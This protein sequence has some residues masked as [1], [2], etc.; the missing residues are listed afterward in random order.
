MDFNEYLSEL[1]KIPEFK[2]VTVADLN[3]GLR[4]HEAQQDDFSEEDLTPEELYQLEAYYAYLSIE[5]TTE[6]ELSED[7]SDLDY[8]ENDPDDWDEDDINDDYYDDYDGDQNDDD[9]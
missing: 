8:E 3:E 7:G 4:I 5:E 9:Y 1:R 6:L 2:N